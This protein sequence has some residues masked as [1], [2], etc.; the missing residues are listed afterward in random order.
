M[1]KLRG[2]YRYALRG[3]GE[4]PERQVKTATYSGTALSSLVTPQGIIPSIDNL[5]RFA[6][7]IR[8]YTPDT[9]PL[10]RL[11]RY[12]PTI[13]VLMGNE[14]HVHFDGLRKGS[15]I[16]RAKVEH[17]DLPKVKNRLNVVG[18]AGAPTDV[19]GEMC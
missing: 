2:K 8:A 3:E 5:A 6:F 19:V 10:E 9:I 4:S 15:T 13:A 18:R 17:E 12:M 7:R 1:K 14:Y 16:L 11:A